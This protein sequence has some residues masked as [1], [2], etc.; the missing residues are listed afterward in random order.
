[1]VFLFWFLLFSILYCY[2]GYPVLIY[3]LSQWKPWPVSRKPITPSV[4]MVLSVWNEDDVIETKLKNIL[5]LDYP[6]DQIEIL[7]ASDGSTD[8]TVPIVRRYVSERI[9]LFDFPDRGGGAGEGGGGK[10]VRLNELARQAQNEIIVFTDARQ[11]FSPSAIRYLVKNFADPKVGCVSGELIFKAMKEG[12]SIGVNVYWEYEKFIRNHESQFHSMLGATG[13][14]YAIRRELYSPV[15]VQAVLDDMYI[16]SKIVLKGYRAI[17]EN[18]ALAYDKPADS[19]LEENRRKTRTI[20]GNYQLIT[21]LPKIYMPGVSPVAF[22]MFSHKLLRIIMP[23]FLI[24]LF[25]VNMQLY[26]EKIYYYFFIAQIVF[27][28]MALLGGLA[29]QV[30]YGILNFIFRICYVPYVFCLLNFSAFSGFL[31]FIMGQQSVT[32]Q[33]ARKKS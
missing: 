27:Y 4:S 1:M 33:K 29:R 32:W 23:F 15:P 30:N 6:A 31:K 22:Q 16:P 5:D 8:Q 2:L 25:A 11:E 24:M 14:I 17:F 7:I 20:Y 28:S 9:K 10:M 18:E 21:L 13:A 26:Q 3:F 12:T 19:P